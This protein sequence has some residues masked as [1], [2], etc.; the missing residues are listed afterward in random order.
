[1]AQRGF[2]ASSFSGRLSAISF[3]FATIRGFVYEMQG[4][5]QVLADTIRARGEGGVNE[6][7]TGG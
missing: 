5:A 2:A 6:P 7:G 1:V 4:F 3:R